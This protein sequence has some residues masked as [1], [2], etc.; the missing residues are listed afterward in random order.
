M[1]YTITP[2]DKRQMQNIFVQMFR[3]LALSAKFTKLTRAGSP[4]PPAAP[5]N[6][7]IVADSDQTRKAS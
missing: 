6:P 7:A 2:R 4:L 3:F 5:E 1:Q